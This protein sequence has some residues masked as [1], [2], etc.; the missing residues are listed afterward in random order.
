[1]KLFTSESLKKRSFGF[2]NGLEMSMSSSL[3]PWLIYS[4]C[5]ELV[6]SVFKNSYS[7]NISLN[8]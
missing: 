2:I 4:K 5:D 8:A 6:S 3:N 1:M 7:E